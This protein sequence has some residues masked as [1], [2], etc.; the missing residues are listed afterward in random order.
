MTLNENEK[1]IPPKSSGSGKTARAI[2]Q[3]IAG[4]VPVLGGVL[5]AAAGAWSEKEQDKMYEFLMA[6]MQ[7]L[8]DE[9]EE[10][11]Q[12][13]ADILLRLDMH[14]EKISERVQTSEYQSLIRK[15]F[16]DWAG[17]ESQQKRNYIRNVLTNA[18]AT[19]ISSDDTVRLFLD[20][21]YRYSEF[22]LAVVGQIY[23][24]TGAT[25]LDIWEGLG[26]E[27]VRDDSA[28]ADLFRLL[29][30]ELSTGGLIRQQRET[31]YQ[32]NFIKSTPK[33][34]QRGTGSR[35]MTSA[36]EDDKPYVLTEL[37]KQFVHYAM[38]DIPPKISYN[39][40]DGLKQQEVA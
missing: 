17:A 35:V 29:I 20:W 13:M 31:D 2:I 22:H 23:L 30:R 37:G 26:R 38:S 12:T 24:N 10:K 8:R 25:R 21:L 36:F 7:M 18:A 33:K 34:P 40:N 3:S 14:D 19:D 4:A 16:R 32:G 5:S 6:Y 15:A 39:P 27:P 9:M 11:H 28:D 1:P